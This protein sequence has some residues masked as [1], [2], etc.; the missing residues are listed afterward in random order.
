VLI[1]DDDAVF[2]GLAARMLRGMGLRVV[3]EADTV[4]AAV[5][6]ARDLRPD[7]ALVDVGLPDGDGFL[8]AHRLADLPHRPRVVLTSSNPD[9]AGPGDAQGSGAV[10]FLAKSDLPNGRLAQLL[11]A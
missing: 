8:L 1:V 3:G 4:A 2:R 10:G 7:A 5:V 9:A 11:A 6:A